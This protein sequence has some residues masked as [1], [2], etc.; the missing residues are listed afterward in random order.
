MR[1]TEM[2]EVALIFREY[3]KKIQA[4]AI[5]SDPNFIGISIVCGKVCYISSRCQE[6]RSIDKNNLFLPQIE[7]YCQPYCI[8]KLSTTKAWIMGEVMIYVGAAFMLILVYS[9]SR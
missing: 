1:S 4:K 3:A 2:G 6:S 9:F 8:E 5:R 7:Q